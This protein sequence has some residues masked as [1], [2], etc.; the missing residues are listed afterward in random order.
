MDLGLLNCGV[1]FHSMTEASPAVRPLSRLSL[2]HVAP[3]FYICGNSLEKK[4]KIKTGFKIKYQ[5]FL[6]MISHFVWLAI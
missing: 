3:W 4:N 2:F 5:A 6:L 1:D